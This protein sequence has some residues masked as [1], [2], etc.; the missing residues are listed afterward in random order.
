VPRDADLGD[1]TTTTRVLPIAGL[2]I[3]IG[4][5]AAYVAAGLL[6]PAAR[7]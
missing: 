4:V 7:V 3:V 2:A 1:F 5:F 6:R